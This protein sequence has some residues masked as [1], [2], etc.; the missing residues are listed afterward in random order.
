M[1][2][3]FRIALSTAVLSAAALPVFADDAAPNT[4]TDAEKAAGFK[5]LFDGKSLDAW[6]GY[7]KDKAPGGWK[8]ADGA[9]V[10]DKKGGGGDLLT[11]EQFDFF[12]LHIDWKITP[13]GNSGI[14]YHVL[15][16][17]K[18]PYMTGPEMQ[19]LDNKGH[20]DGKNPKTSAGSLYAMIAPAKDVTKSPGEWN[21]ARLI[22]RPDGSCEHWLNGEKIV[23]YKKGGEAWDK[24]IAGSKFKA[25]ATFGKATKGHIDLQDHGDRVEYRNIKIRVIPADGK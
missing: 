24:M 8:V 3:R 21:S 2:A 16:T 19:V 14:M 12:E 13:K 7:K 20:G 22:V 17:E 9:I 25:W 10:F 1:S 18:A 6:R 23:E 15:E 4:L 11:V 5:L